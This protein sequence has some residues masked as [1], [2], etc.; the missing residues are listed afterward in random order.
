VVV[1]AQAGGEVLVVA[2]VVQAV[3]KHLPTL[4]LFLLQ[5]DRP[6]V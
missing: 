3:I 6:I 1:V 5:P 2:A 4:L